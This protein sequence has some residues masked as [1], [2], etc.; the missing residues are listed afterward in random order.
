MSK[1]FASLWPLDPD[2][3][4][5]NHGSFGSCPRPVLEFQQALRERMERQ[6][7]QFLVRELEGLVDQ[8]RGALAE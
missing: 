8:A 2:V 7:V 6:P 5:L 4:F 1:A 3:L